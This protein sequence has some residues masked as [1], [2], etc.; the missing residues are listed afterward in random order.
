MKN[1]TKSQSTKA[2]VS[3]AALI[4][5]VGLGASS[6]NCAAD[7]LYIGDTS[8]NTVKS[9]DAATGEFLGATVKRS[10]SGLHGPRGLLMDTGSDL[11]ASDQNAGTSTAGDILEYDTATGKLSER[12]V[13][14]SDPDAPSVPRGIILSGGNLFVA[15]LTTKKGSLLP[16]SCPVRLFRWSNSTRGAW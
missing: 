6:L 1:I 2:S 8:D 13:P 12:V 7:S 15:D 11:L 9:F 16:I 4:L 14:H 10:L 5:A 3:V